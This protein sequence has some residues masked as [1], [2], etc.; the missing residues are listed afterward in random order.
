MSLFAALAFAAA[1]PAAVEAPYGVLADGRPVTQVTL[2][3][4]RGMVVKLIGY[5]AIVTD[6]V[7]PDGQGRAENVALG[8][9][10]LGEYEAKNANY[11]FGAIVGRY[12]GR[13]AGAR[14]TIDGEEY[15]LGAND[16][17]N[18][19]H[20]GPGG[21]DMALWS[22]EPFTRGPVA[23]AVMRTASPAGDQGFPGRLDVTVTYSLTPDNA[24]RIDYQAIADAPTHLNLTNH[25]Y[26]NLAGAGEGTIRGHRLQILS[27]KL[28]DTAAKGIPTGEALAGA[29]TPFDLRAPRPIGEAMARPHRLME[30]SRGYNHGWILSGE[31]L[32]TAAILSDPASGRVMEVLTTEPSLHVYA[33]NWFGGEDVGAQGVPYPPDAGIALEAQAFPDAPNRPAFPSTL[34]RPGETFRSTTIYRFSAAPIG[35]Q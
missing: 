30:G 17:P 6:I 34:L 13:I 10:T 20:G 1:A 5:G 7:V 8:F 16:P 35:A 27:D 31:G 15:R 9:A 4:D 25:S 33:A 18:A 26:V 3:N 11:D 28:I 23:G 21:L 12:A 14:F 2:T 24:L 22:V 19:L 32:R 29:G